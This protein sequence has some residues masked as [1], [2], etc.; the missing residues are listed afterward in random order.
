LDL[1]VSKPGET[2]HPPSHI[3][4]SFGCFEVTMNVLSR[5]EI[6]RRAVSK[7]V[8]CISNDENDLLLDVLYARSAARHPHLPPHSRDWEQ[9]SYVFWW[10]VP[11]ERSVE[12]IRR[13]TRVPARVPRSGALNADRRCCKCGVSRYLPSPQR[14]VDSF[15]MN[16]CLYNKPSGPRPPIFTALLYAIFGTG[17]GVFATWK[18]ANDT[19]DLIPTVLPSGP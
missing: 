17:S 10:K 18:L 5:S 14:P 7:N 9:G 13:F 8:W 15:S 19:R 16:A 11:V 2:Q 6:K 4:S 3:Q 12:V 1:N